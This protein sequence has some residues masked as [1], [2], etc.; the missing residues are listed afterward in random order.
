MGLESYLAGRTA[1]ISTYLGSA[2]ST[3]LHSDIQG[4]KQIA[5]K[6]S[7]EHARGR[8]LAVESDVARSLRRVQLKRL[9]RYL[10]VILVVGVVISGLGWLGWRQWLKGQR[11]EGWYIRDHIA[12]LM[13]EGGVLELPAG[14]YQLSTPILL[15]KPLSLK[16]SGRERTRVTFKEGTSGLMY[17]ADGIFAVADI[18]L[19]YSGGQPANVVTIQTVRS[20]FNGVASRAAKA[21]NLCALLGMVF[22]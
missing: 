15:H 6:G 7:I 9:G 2:V 20:T 22:S 8:I 10:T 21:D 14:D 19:E 11:K 12:E 17:A 3:K 13:T 18:S 4:A 5:E 1:I 16:G